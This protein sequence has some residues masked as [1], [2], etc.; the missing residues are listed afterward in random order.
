MSSIRV[1]TNF[2]DNFGGDLGDKLITKDY[3]MSVY[4]SIAQEIG[5]T[6]ELWTW[7]LDT[8][9][10]LG[11]ASTSAASTPITTFSGGTNWR[12]VSSGNV[13]T[14]ATKTDGTL[15]TWGGGSNG[16]LGN[17]STVNVSTPVTTFAGGTN[18]KYASSGGQHTAATKTDGT[19]WTWGG[20]SNG[21]LGNALTTNTSTPVTVSVGS[22]WK[23][24]SGGG[25]H[26]AAI[27]IDGTLWAWGNNTYGRL[28]NG[29]T[30][31]S[32]GNPSTTFAGGTNW[33]QVSCGQ[34]HIAAIKT[35]GT[36]WT[37]GQGA[38][39]EL[40]N[41][42]TTN[43]STPVTTFAGGT[44]WKQVSSGF[45]FIAAIKT[46]GTLWVWGTNSSRQLGTNDTI[47]SKS[48]PVTTFAG[49]TNWK[50][51]SCSVGANIAAI[52]TDGTLWTWGN[53]QF[54]KN[55]N[56][57]S[58]GG[59]QSIRSTPVT[60]FGG[61]TNWKQVSCGQQ[62]TSAIKTDGTL[63]TWGNGINGQLGN[64]VTG[65]IVSTPSTTFSGGTNWT[66]ASS[67]TN[68]SAAIKTDG[69]LW[70][71]GGG[72]NGRLGNAS[73]VNVSTPVT[74]F[75]G[76][77]NWRDALSTAP[78][79]LYTVSTGTNHAAAIKTD[80]TLWTWGY[81][82]FGQ[83]GINVI[84]TAATSLGVSTPSVLYF[85]QNLWR[86][87][88]SGNVHTAATKTDGTLWVW[89]SGASGRLGTN[90]TTNAS[91]PVTTFAGGTDWKQVSAGYGHT[92]AIKTDGTLW[93][94]G[95]NSTGGVG[96]AQLGTNDT[97]DRLTPVTTFAGG[98]NWKQVSAGYGHTAAIKTDG[99]LWTWGNG[100]RL[101]TNNGFTIST[102]VTTFAGGTN[103]KGVSCG[104]QNTIAIKT[105]GTLW[106]WGVATNGILGNASLSSTNTPVTTFA[107]GTN[108]KQSSAG[109]TSAAAIRSADFI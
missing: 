109:T 96:R 26:G 57:V 22:D 74:T 93:T 89:G 79:D 36:L 14:A 101:G 106:T 39:G 99:T 91:I 1:T 66:Q 104:L 102:P 61:G 17:A 24:V 85:G 20:G 65:I 69:T 72:V 44:N 81:N 8:S 16:R 13:H 60:V 5:K 48:T 37:W 97:I 54:G 108:W 6:P 4:P 38:I 64:R 86:Q 105:D 40:G 29:S 88:S 77:T 10:Q 34:N 33:K 55:G 15:W 3:L 107:G 51:V 83:L 32:L 78:E 84:T 103:W 52:K 95:S 90:V 70:T 73:T 31:S 23:Q 18:W 27:N 21:Q 47:S 46:D 12:Q 41:A 68:F 2:K 19:L 35:D 59:L 92:A 58:A 76:G 82:S 94:W 28:G 50:Q 87:V 25:Q 100:G 30:L 63:W 9:G 71:W 75:S 42:A 62:H 43:R 45:G 56:A 11:N 67:G 80:G 98:T 53:G 49:G 7:G